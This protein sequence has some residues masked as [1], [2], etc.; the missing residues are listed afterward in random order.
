MY[1]NLL[2]SQWNPLYFWS[3]WIQGCT[4]FCFCQPH[5]FYLYEVRPPTCTTHTYCYDKLLLPS[6]RQHRTHSNI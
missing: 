5:Y 6:A 4:T 3:L 1:E 2:I